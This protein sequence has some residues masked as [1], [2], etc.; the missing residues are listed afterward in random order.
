MRI[1]LERTP[2]P[3]DLGDTATCAICAGDF[4]I[5]VVWAMLLTKSRMDAGMVCPACVEYMGNH[6]SGRF[7]TIEQYRHLEGEWKTARYSSV[8]EAD[9]ALGF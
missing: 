5:G 7:P 6:P 1:E 4:E 2:L 8:E 3:E 9:R